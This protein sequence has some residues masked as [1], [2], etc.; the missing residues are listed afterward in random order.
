MEPA[1]VAETSDKIDGVESDDRDHQAADTNTTIVDDIDVEPAVV[2]ETSDKV[3]RIEP[4]DRVPTNVSNTD[5]NTVFWI[6][7]TMAVILFFMMYIS[8]GLN[9]WNYVK[10][11]MPGCVIV[12][13][14]WFYL[15]QRAAKKRTSQFEQ[16]ALEL[17][18]SFLPQGDESLLDRQGG[19][20]LF[21][22][23]RGRKIVNM[24]HGESDGVELAIFDYRYRTGNGKNS[25]TIKQSVIYFCSTTL[26]LPKFAVR[27]E[28]L[29]HKIGELFGYPDIDFQSHSR[30]S[31]QYLLQ[32]DDE[33][34]VRAVFSDELLTFFENQ[35]KISVE[36]NGDQMIFY[37]PGKRIAPDQCKRFMEEG[38]GVFTR[39]QG[40]NVSR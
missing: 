14:L 2:A 10:W 7:W 37:R 21:L 11:L 22:R 16:V 38:F 30:F 13:G 12:V 36:G 24:L 40:R 28:R 25:S 8:G 9:D 19:F 18:L 32:G 39:F 15:G 4:H 17:G 33:A 6:C 20:H 26:H 1:V 3:V 23:G 27:Q 31:K 34:A 5:K 29:F 35:Q